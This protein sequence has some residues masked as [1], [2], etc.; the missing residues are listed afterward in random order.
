MTT[1]QLNQTQIRENFSESYYARGRAYFKQEMILSLE[2]I[3][4]SDKEAT[5]TSMTRGSHHNHYTQRIDIQWFDDG[6]VDITGHCS[7]PMRVNCKHVVAACLK[8][9]A[10]HAPAQLQQASGN[11]CMSWLDD[12]ICSESEPTHNADKEFIL[13]LLKPLGHP[14]QVT[15]NLLLT[16]PLKRGGISKGRIIRLDQL[17]DSYY[18]PDYAQESDKE[19]TSLLSACPQSGWQAPITLEGSVG[20]AAL[21]KMVESGR[22]H[23][24]NSDNPPLQY[25]T[26]RPL[27]IEW[28]Q[29]KSGD[30]HL[31]S[32]VTGGG[33]VILTTPALYIDKDEHIVGPLTEAN[34]TKKQLKK[35]LYPVSIPA[36]HL[37]QFS[38]QLVTALPNRL[39]PPVKVEITE[40][41]DVKP[42]PRLLLSAIEHSNQSNHHIYLDFL[43]MEQSIDALPANEIESFNKNGQLIHIWRDL[44]LEQTAIERV[45]L[46]GFVGKITPNGR[47]ISFSSPEQENELDSLSRWQDFLTNQVPILQ[48]EGW[49]IERDEQF[50]MV[51][52]ESEDWS[53][54]VEGDN[55]WFNLRFDIEV[56][57]KKR[58]LLP[59][60]TAALKRFDRDHLP[61]ILHLPLRGSEYLSLPSKQIKPIL[62]IL[63][64]LYDGNSLDEDGALQLSRFDAGRLSELEMGSTEMVWLGGETLRELGKKLNDFNGIQPITPPEGLKAELRHYQQQG[65]DWLQFLREHQFNGILADDMG[66]GK[67]VQT[68]AH[69]LYEKREGRLTQPCLIIAPTSLMSNWW[70]EVAQFTPELKV[71]ILQG[72]GRLQHFDKIDQHDLILSTY[73]LLV[74]DEER[75]LQHKFHYLVLDEAQVVK[76]PKSK[77]AKV[78]RQI[79]CNHRLCLTGTPMENHLGEL[80]ALFDFLMP[81]FLGDSKQFKTLFRTPIEKYN[82]LEQ[83]QRLS[84]RVAPF[85]LRRTK[86]EVA[87]ELPAKTEIILNVTLGSK[88]AALY[89]SIRIAMD[90]K[91]RKAIASKGLARSHIM[92]LDALLK[93]RQCCCDPQLLKLD[94]AKAV[95]DSAKLELLMTL[96]PEMVEEGRRILLFSQF[97]QMLSIIEEQLKQHKISYCKLTG[98]TRK[99]DKVIESFKQGEADVFLISLKAGGVG[100]NLTEADT[101]IHYD[102]WWNPAAEN[103]ATD[104]AHRIGQDKAVF[105]YKLITENTLEEQIIKMQTKKQALTDGVYKKESVADNAAISNYDLQ[106]LFAPLAG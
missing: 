16:R 20:F 77:A 23:W 1:K 42:M 65:L 72:S 56:N 36:S 12:F 100:L 24:A 14:G 69:L 71:L 95:H 92:I 91:V 61:E 43:Y 47:G 64:E 41:R 88:Q 19:I 62:D 40:V 82:K 26:E 29:D 18:L 28:Q 39:P 54:N 17:S 94:Q 78:I 103:Q 60:V 89:E 9:Q 98:Q 58:P 67:T 38:Q 13:Y 70:R 55:D 93:L 22:C 44:A 83:Q 2:V 45:E 31:S 73:P 21:S 66:L 4:D 49:Q 85:M 75:L 59:L 27:N 74:R 99:R 90:K 63:Y 48:D 10:E 15:V 25:G 30:A 105:V 34:F 32:S 106:A 52:H 97:T 68:L 33:I 35:L 96:L 102:P 79:R 46:L 37:D 101:V 11:I 80:W 7:C 57:G 3:K 87:S 84:K 53:A 51:F 8:Y 6:D 86:G 81:G 50:K 5:L 76:N 104:R